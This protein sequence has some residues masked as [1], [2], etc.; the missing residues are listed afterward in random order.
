MPVNDSACAEKMRGRVVSDLVTNIPLL[1]DTD[2]ENI[3][4]FMIQLK[5]VHDLKIVFDFE[6]L[7]LTVGRT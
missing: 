6:I 4:K 2:P 1:T 7:S 3:F 5:E